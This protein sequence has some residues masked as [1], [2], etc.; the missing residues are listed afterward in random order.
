MTMEK[1]R[2]ESIDGDQ[3][4]IELM[5]NPNELD[6]QLKTAL[7]EDQGARTE[8]EGI[9]KVSFA[10]P[11]AVIVNIK[12]MIYDTYET[13]DGVKQYIE[14]LT[15]ATKFIE[16][17][18]RPPIYMLT[19]GQNKFLLCFVE[20]LKYQLTMFKPDGTPVRAKASVTL[21]QVDPQEVL[22]AGGGLVANRESYDRFNPDSS[23]SGSQNYQ[24]VPR[25]N[26][27]AQPS[28]N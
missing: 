28:P 8:Q 14:R 1:L 10:Y 4:T 22:N 16:S 15:K 11:N 18:K 12:D 24:N 25:N 17:K 21:K 20:S 5:F 13:G 19:W 9:P 2:L 26:G 3:Y 27:N 6:F 23:W 7:T